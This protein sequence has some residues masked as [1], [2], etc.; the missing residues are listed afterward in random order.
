MFCSSVRDLDAADEVAAVVVVSVVVVAVEVEVELLGLV[1]V[2]EEE[3][4]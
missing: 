2:L 4:R 3:W 1:V